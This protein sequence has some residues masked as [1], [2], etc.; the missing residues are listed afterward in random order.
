M[1]QMPVLIHIHMPDG[2][3]LRQDGFTLVVN[4]RGCVLAM[5]TRPEIG[6]HMVLVNP[7]SG[8]EQS[9]AVIRAQRSRDGGY[10]VAFQFDNPTPQFWSPVL[11]PEEGK[12][13]PR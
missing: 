3:L 11:L 4:S 10:A 7:T 12:G 8:V 5:E 6:Q 13:G 9:G 1:I 2:R